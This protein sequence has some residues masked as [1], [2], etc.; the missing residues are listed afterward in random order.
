M[1]KKIYS[2]DTSRIVWGNI[3]LQSKKACSCPC[4]N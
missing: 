3:E 1:G 2:L 4:L